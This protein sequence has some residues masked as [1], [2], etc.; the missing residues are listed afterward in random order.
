MKER[1]GFGGGFKIPEEIRKRKELS[2]KNK[3]EASVI[4]NDVTAKDQSLVT[5]DEVLSVLNLGNAECGIGSGK[6]G[7]NSKNALSKDLDEALEKD[8]KKLKMSEENIRHRRIA[9]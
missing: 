1:T 7:P 6:N 3:I 5:K 9:A 2:K 8:L 4:E